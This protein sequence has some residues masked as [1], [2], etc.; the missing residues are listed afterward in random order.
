MADSITIPGVGPVNKK[1]AAI[2]GGGVISAVVAV[3]IY[4]RK[5]AAATAAAAPADTSSDDSSGLIDPATGVPY[6]DEANGLDSFDPGSGGDEFD[7]GNFDPA[8]YPIGSQADLAW[9]AQQA[10]TGLGIPGTTVTT[11][12]QWV[13]AAEQQLGNTSA[14]SSALLSVLGGVAVTAAQQQ[15]FQQAVGFLGPPPQGYPPI[16]LTST[17]GAPA[18]PTGTTVATVTVPN[19]RGKRAAIQAIPAIQ[20]AG[21]VIGHTSPPINPVHEYTVAGQTPAAGAKVPRG[22]A[23]DLQLTQIK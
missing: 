18:P 15:V 4:R 10:G 3:S 1:K 22:S 8:G 13:E 20:A 17:S 21:L 7:T 6:A 14:V 23:V 16:N 9:Q 12:S 5:S 2:I 11:N 19:V